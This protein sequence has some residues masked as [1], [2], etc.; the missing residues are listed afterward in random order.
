M[1]LQTARLTL[2]PFTE[3]DAAF[4]LEFVNHA[5]ARVLERAGL[6]FER[7]LPT[8]ADGKALHRFAI[9]AD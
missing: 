2:R 1:T 3:G 4:M 7:P 6:R 8:G 9:E 5:S